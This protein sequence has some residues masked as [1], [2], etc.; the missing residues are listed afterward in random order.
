MQHEIFEQA[1]RLFAERGFAG[2]S[3]QDIADAVGLT[4]PALYHYVKSK[5]DLLAKLVAEVTVV[6]ATD[7]AEVA[8]RTELSATER[9]RDIVRLMVRHQGEQGERFRLLLR[10]EADLPDSVAG[11]Y[12]ENRRAVLRSLT[13]VI[14]QGVAH[15]EFRPVTPTVAAFGTLGIVNWVAWWYHP[16]SQFDLDAI[17]AELAEQAVHSLAAEQGRPASATPLDAVHSIRREIDR[18]EGLLKEA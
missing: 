16:G 2:T 1:T 4:R 3:F 12:A 9:I 7:I 5:D 8:Q 10:S 11:S 15:G 18:L 6:A 13:E 17:C 14:E